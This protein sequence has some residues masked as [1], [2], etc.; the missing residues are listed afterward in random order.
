MRPEGAGERNKKW[1]CVTGEILIP[2]HVVNKL[3]LR[4]IWASIYEIYGRHEI[5]LISYTHTYRYMGF[6][7]GTSGKEPACQCRRQEMWV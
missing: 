4:D 2:T 7:G 3:H 6:P 5:Y 1:A